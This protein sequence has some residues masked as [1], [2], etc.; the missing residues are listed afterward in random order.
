MKAKNRAV[1]LALLAAVALAKGAEDAAGAYNNNNKDQDSFS[2]TTADHYRPWT[3]SDY[4]R[5]AK[6]C[7][8]PVS[9]NGCDPDEVF[10]DRDWQAI[11]QV[12]AIPSMMQ[13][14]CDDDHESA[15]ATVQVGVAITRKLDLS[16]YHGYEDPQERA[17]RA[18]ARG[19]HDIWG[20]GET[21][22]CGGTGVLVFLSD[23]DRTVYISRGD[24]LKHVLTD[25]R[26]DRVIANMKPFLQRQK[27]KDAVLGAL[28][29]IAHLIQKG[30]PQLAERVQDFL[31]TYSGLL[32]VGAIFAFLF[33]QARRSRA[34]QRE[35]A[36]AAAHLD[37]IERVRAEALQ[38]HFQMESCPICLEKFPNVE[39]SNG[40][41]RCPTMGSDGLPLKLLRCGHCFDETCWNEWVDTGRGQIGRCPICQQSVGRDT[42]SAPDSAVVDQLDTTDELDQQRLLD[43]AASDG[44]TDT[45]PAQQIDNGIE[46]HRTLQR[47]QH[48]RNFR[49]ARLGAR[50][51]RYITQQQ[52]QR[53]SSSTY[54]GPLARDPTFVERDP[55]NTQGN[56]NDRIKSSGRSGSSS[57]GGS[58][59]GGSFGGGRSGGGRGGRW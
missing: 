56:N 52:I 40:E 16:G 41:T 4:P 54:N 55:Q 35:Y 31:V 45:D 18:F 12:L 30:K 50:Y 59:S 20:V 6:V 7:R 17:A 28:D 58:N 47:Y 38:G 2:S 57:S 48:E 15:A 11:D 51:P 19:L 24:A 32:W 37:E 46:R 43:P 23:L 49:L 53:W 1:I 25:R 26:I 14:S 33:T 9:G 10:S 5:L 39:G 13:I 29:E 36:A 27:Y 42:S 21:L 3:L 22:V 44:P 8:T 34:A